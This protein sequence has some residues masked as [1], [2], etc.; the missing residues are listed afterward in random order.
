MELQ[1]GQLAVREISLAD[2]P[3]IARYWVDADP[4]YL[5]GMGVD[6]AK[7]PAEGMWISMLTEQ[8]NTPVRDRKSYALIWLVDGVPAGHC[9]INKISFGEEAY[10]HLH[11]WQQ[12]HRQK[13]MGAALVR[14]SLPYFFSGFQLQRIYSEPYALNPAPNKTL[15]RAG[16]RFVGETITTP[17][18]LN[19]EQPVNL[20]VIEKK[21]SIQ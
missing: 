1:Q 8:V 13:G 5:K 18:I 19:F 10:M 17:G 15:P 7:M 16:F 14:M 3:L 11:L 12:P 20:W 4:E 9:N 2:V 6:L 21:E